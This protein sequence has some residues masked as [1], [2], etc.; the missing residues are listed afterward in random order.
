MDAFYPVVLADEACP[1]TPVIFALIV[2]CDID[3][4]K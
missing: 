2:V 4:L 1:E 3:M